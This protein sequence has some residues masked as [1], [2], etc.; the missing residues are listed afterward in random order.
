MRRSLCFAVLNLAFALSL[1]GFL[2]M[3]IN[4]LYRNT[5]TIEA[6]EKKAS[7]K[8]KYDVGGRKN[9]EQVFGSTPLFWFIPLYSPDD[10]RRMAVLEGVQFPVRSEGGG[11]LV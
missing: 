2:V 4:L 9:F 6:Y 3:H 11:G 5:T 8:W 7:A 10:K 1:C